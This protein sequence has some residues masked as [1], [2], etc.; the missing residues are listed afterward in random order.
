MITDAPFRL[1][2]AA[3]RDL[4]RVQLIVGLAGLLM[5]LISVFVVLPGAGSGLAQPVAAL[6]FALGVVFPFVISLFLLSQGWPNDKYINVP[7]K[8]KIFI[9][10]N[11]LRWVNRPALRPPLARLARGGAI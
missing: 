11:V 7:K 2:R 5:I 6:G 9:K 10:I 1:S 3:T 4:A 8:R